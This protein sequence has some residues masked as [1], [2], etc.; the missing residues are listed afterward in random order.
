MYIKNQKE[1][2]KAIFD[3]ERVCINKEDIIIDKV[4]AIKTCLDP[5]FQLNKILTRR[6]KIKLLLFNK[7]LNQSINEATSFITNKAGLGNNSFIENKVGS[8]LQNAF[9]TVFTTNRYKVKAVGIALLKNIF[10]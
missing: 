5:T 9:Y 7:Q 6:K 8:F 3:L 10:R 4:K 1:L 2:A